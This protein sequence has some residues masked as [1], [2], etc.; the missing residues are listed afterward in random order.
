MKEKDVVFNDEFIKALLDAI[1][2]DEVDV[3]VICHDDGDVDVRTC[4]DLPFDEPN[5]EEFDEDDE[6]E[7]NMWGFGEDECAS[8]AVPDIDQVIFSGPATVILWEDGEK[9]MVKCAED[10]TYDKYSGFCAAVCKRL[11]GSST[12]VKKLI[13]DRDPEV[14]RQR[15]EEIRKAQAEE[16]RAKE[17]AAQAK[18]IL[19]DLEAMPSLSE[20]TR[21]VNK[22][23]VEMLIEKSARE[24]LEFV[25]KKA[26]VEKVTEAMT[27][28]MESKE[29]EE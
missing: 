23:A 10:Q 9:T 18:K 12:A 16:H 17:R 15:L 26:S 1:I 20:F 24:K 25:N 2:P 21:A 7:E 14:R 19:R 6:D 4:D 28:F 27:D 3:E 8:F 13:E 5:C 22:R 11:F 29:G